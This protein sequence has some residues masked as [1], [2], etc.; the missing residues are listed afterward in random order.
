MY[1]NCND[2]SLVLNLSRKPSINLLNVFAAMLRVRANVI[3]DHNGNIQSF[4]FTSIL[5]MH[6]KVSS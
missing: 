3:D 6:W 5:N 2:C 4:S 1:K